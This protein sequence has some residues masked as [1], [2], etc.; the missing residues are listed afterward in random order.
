MPSSQNESPNSYLQEE[1]EEIQSVST[2][3]DWGLLEFVFE[4]IGFIIFSDD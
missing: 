3:S 1:N 4:F 2:S